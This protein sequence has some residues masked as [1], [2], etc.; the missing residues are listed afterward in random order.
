MY[1]H[2]RAQQLSWF[3]VF[4]QSTVKEK[5]ERG[6][7]PCCKPSADGFVVIGTQ[8]FCFPVFSF[9]HV[10]V[11]LVWIP[12]AECHVHWKVNRV[13]W[14]SL[15]TDHWSCQIYYT[16]FFIDWLG[17]ST[18]PCVC[19]FQEVQTASSYVCTVQY[20]VYKSDVWRAYLQTCFKWPLS[21]D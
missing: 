15:M 17:V 5:V 8:P 10:F 11:K 6:E 13:H 19:R 14:T 12:K 3:W 7:L 4:L 2:Q 20:T 1:L 18:Q 9:R 21:F 16:L